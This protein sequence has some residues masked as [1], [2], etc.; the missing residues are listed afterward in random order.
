MFGSEFGWHEW[1]IQPRGF[2]AGYCTGTCADIS[3]R[4]DGVIKGTYINKKKVNISLK[5]PSLFYTFLGI[6]AAMV[7]SKVLSKLIFEV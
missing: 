2:E 1:V 4:Q 6:L 5:Y 7:D 3:S